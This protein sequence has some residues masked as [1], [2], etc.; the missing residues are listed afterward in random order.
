MNFSELEQLMSSRGV[1]TLADIA[2]TL[3]TTPQAVSN[4]KARNQVPHHVVAKISQKPN[5]PLV[6]S[7]ITLP[8]APLL[9]EED[10][11]TLSD[12]LITIAEQLKVIFIT[13]VITLFTVV[14]S[15]WGT[16]EVKYLS[17]ATIL[18]PENK[19]ANSGLSGLANQ[20]GVNLQQG[21]STTDLSSPSLFPE[22]VKSRIFGERI[23]DAVFYSEKYQKNL[24][25]FEI[26]T[27][28]SKDGQFEYEALKIKAIANF[29]S[30]V[31]FK[32]EKGLFSLLIVTADEPKLARDIN[33]KVLDELQELS[34]FFTN[35][36][37]AE[38]IR[39]I[40]SRIEAVDQ[41]LENS[42]QKLKVFRERNRQ[43]SSPALVLDEERL[44]RNVEIQKGIFLTLRQQLEL[45]NIEKIQT[46][47]V[48]RILDKPDLPIVGS[49]PSMKN[50][51]LLS[52]FIGFGLGIL[53]AFSRSYVNNNDIDER[54]KLRRVR[55]FFRR[56]GQDI[57]L[58]RRISGIISIM[59]IVGL[60]YYLGHE[61]E[62]PVYFGM[63]SSK[64]MSINLIY[65]LILILSIFQFFYFSKKKKI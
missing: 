55:N 46:E 54:R 2:R 59:M 35:E 8:P 47:T 16:Y 39:F 7:S 24:S 57:F 12:I 17:T 11:N 28:G 1:T 52:I 3:N 44:S 34:R 31:T 26:L 33:I 64:M 61:S 27:P 9:I 56:K 5:E 23:L 37:I 19:G 30:M 14:T 60:P 42:E 25:L 6:S 32:E 53:L 65:L 15:T 41:E 48:V 62:N 50:T 49:A 22:L 43:L 10:S 36:K 4:W 29:Q 45:A 18:L 40:Q 51:A 63:Y 13:T 58:D 20:F 38:K 21:G